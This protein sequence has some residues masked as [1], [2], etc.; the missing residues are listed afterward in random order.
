MIGYEVKNYIEK[1]IKSHA[2]RVKDKAVSI[3]RLKGDEDKKIFEKGFPF[4]SLLSADGDFD[5]REKTAELQFDIPIPESMGAVEF[6]DVSA[7]LKVDDRDIFQNIYVRDGD[8]YKKKTLIS[9]EKSS[10]ISMLK[11]LGYNLKYRAYIRGAVKYLLEIRVFC[12]TEEQSQKLLRD[13][14]RNIPDM[15]KLNGYEG[16][17]LITKH[18]SSDW[19]SNVRDCVLSYCYVEFYMDVGTDPVVIPTVVTAKMLRKG[20]IINGK[21]E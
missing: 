1:I 15:W 2:G 13:I 3:V 8:V 19:S 21:K 18:G 5:E 20:G 16:K 9:D 14:V 7:K 17:I 10:L 11:P 6:A 12:E 4:V